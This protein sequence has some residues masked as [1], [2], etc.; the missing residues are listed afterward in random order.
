MRSLLLLALVL[1]MA[2]CTGGSGV[3]SVPTPGQVSPPPATVAAT[4]SLAEA[5]TPT[6][7][8]TVEPTPTPEPTLGLDFEPI[9]L[10]GSGSKVPKFSIPNVQAIATITYSGSAYFAVWM[11]GDDGS[12]IDLLVNRAGKYS[13]TVLLD[14]PSGA[15]PAAFSVTASGAWTITVKPLQM[16]RLWDTSTSLTG[17][18]DDVVLLA[19][20]AGG[21][22]TATINYTGSTAFAVWSYGSAYP[23]LMVNEA[24][25]YSGDVPLS[26]GTTYLAVE[27]IGSWSVSLS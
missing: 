19:A 4:P 3:T 5:P 21:L 2:G 12:K 7:V 20:P 11:L 22:V 16:A 27:C 26:P 25:P 10:S 24:G 15:H 13:G 6:P 9:S 18:G 23:D 1:V 8:P 17:N 14:V